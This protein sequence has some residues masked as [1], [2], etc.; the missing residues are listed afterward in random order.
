[1]EISIGNGPVEVLHSE[2]DIADAVCKRMES[3][4][5][6]TVS[7]IAINLRICK[8]EVPTMEIIDLPGISEGKL[9]ADVLAI[10]SKYLALPETLVLCVVDA[11]FADLGSSQAIALVRQHRK[12]ANTIIVLTKADSVH[13]R[14][15]EKQ[16]IQ[17]VL[18]ER[19]GEDITGFAGCVAVINRGHRDQVSLLEADNEE[20]SLF[21]DQVFKIPPM[22]PGLVTGSL[23]SSRQAEVEQHIT[24]TKLIEQVLTLYCK[25]VRAEWMPQ[26]FKTI[27]PLMEAALADL[28]NLGKPPGSRLKLQQILDHAS[29]LTNWHQLA[30]ITLAAPFATSF[31]Q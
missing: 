11:S 17:R 20:Q 1:M 7:S 15:V 6:G 19:P 13:P 29:D 18:K 25:H 26:A 31:I 3:I 14:E 10:V 16:I 9:K 24:S 27:G 28:N 8:P 30:S 23:F 21:R 12:E 5:E 22:W 4:P 2:A